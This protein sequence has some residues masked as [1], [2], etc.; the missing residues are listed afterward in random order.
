MYIIDGVKGVVIS[1]TDSPN[2]RAL[3]AK[4]SHGGTLLAT[5]NENGS[6]VL[7]NTDSWE[8]DKSLLYHRGKVNDVDFSAT[9]HR[10]VSV[11]V[12]KNVVIWDVA[13]GVALKIFKRDYFQLVWS[14]A[15]SPD[16]EVF[17]TDH[18]DSII[19]VRSCKTGKKEVKLRGHTS[20][21]QCMVFSP[22]GGLLASCGDTSFKLWSL[23]DN[24]LLQ[25]LDFGVVTSVASFSPLGETIAVGCEDGSITLL[26]TST[27]ML[28]H[29]FTL[30][31]N[32]IRSVV[33]SFPP[34]AQGM[35]SAENSPMHVVLTMCR[36]QCRRDCHNA[37]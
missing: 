1:S 18:W 31:Q 17:A 13:K 12:D 22:T 34:S 4:F 7:Y 16:G 20:K 27:R 29:K 37:M 23:I 2:V 19:A 33:F 24:T 5:F 28:L 6:V 26:N 11:S 8:I 14:V 3:G 25:N 21:V 35:F 9:D 15:L 36:R 10:L 30:L 32:D